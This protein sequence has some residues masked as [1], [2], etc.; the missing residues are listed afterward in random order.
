M[1]H[2]ALAVLVLSAAAC[3]DSTSEPGVTPSGVFSRSDTSSG[4]PVKLAFVSGRG[5]RVAIEVASQGEIEERT[6]FTY[7]TSSKLKATLKKKVITGR[8]VSTEQD[9]QDRVVEKSVAMTSDGAK[10]DS[11]GFLEDG[12]FAYQRDGATSAGDMLK[13]CP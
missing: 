8:G 5:A 6:C 7:D 2:I 9:L 4:K 11:D 13:D 12:K 3:S 10:I 1:K